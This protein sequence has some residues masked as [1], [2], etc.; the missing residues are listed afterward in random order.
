M[1]NPTGIGKII[2][3]LGI[4]TVILPFLLVFVIV[5]AVL[6]K[7]RI[8]GENPDKTPKTNLDVLVSFVFA[9]AFIAYLRLVVAVG[10]ILPYTAV[11][12]IMLVLIEMLLSAL[13]LD[14]Q[15]MK[16]G[17]F[18]LILGIVILVIFGIGVGFLTSGSLGSVKSFIFHPIVIG[19]VIFVLLA[20]FIVKDDK[21]EG[22]GGEEKRGGGE[23]VSREEI[24]SAGREM[25]PGDRRT[26][27]RI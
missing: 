4:D 9:F 10:H 16:S 3:D 6:Q 14:L 24:E 23:S 11:V 1:A 18:K 26:L 27:R 22:K 21:K 12:L 20:W 17:W 13:G 25:Q 19:A 2:S 15:S 8:F 7:T 5:F